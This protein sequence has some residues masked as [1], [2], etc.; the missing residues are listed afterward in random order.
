M[1]TFVISTLPGI[2]V[3]WGGA[4]GVLRENGGGG[5]EGPHCLG[6]GTEFF[7]RGKL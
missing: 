7:H 3:E 2:Y 4:R 5:G 1:T 6:R